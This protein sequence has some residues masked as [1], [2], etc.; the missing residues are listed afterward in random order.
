MWKGKG[1]KEWIGSCSDLDLCWSGVD[2][3]DVAVGDGGVQVQLAYLYLDKKK[4]I[5]MGT[6]KQRN[7]KREDNYR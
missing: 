1:S 7:K 4:G 5:E 6:N 3:L 2:V